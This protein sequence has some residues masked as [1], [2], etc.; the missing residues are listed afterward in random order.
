MEETNELEAETPNQEE[1][2]S[3]EPRVYTA[4]EVEAIKKKM[5]SD[6]E[7][8]VQ[9]LIAKNK[10]YE[11]VLEVV[12]KV[13]DDQ[14]YLVDYYDTNPEVAQII[15]EKYYGGQS[16][17]EFKNSIGY[18]I[19]Y[20]DPTVR[21]RHIELEAQKIVEKKLVEK[22]KADFIA[23]LWMSEKEKKDFEEAFE[24][25]RQLKSF[26][27]DDLE[28]QLTKAYRE[29]SDNT[30]VLKNLK[31]QEVIGKAMATWEGKWGDGGT[32]KKSGIQSEIADFLKKYS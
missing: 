32:V 11:S 27:I 31:T 16:I 24:E 4:E 25:R 20:S 1:E 6:S 28:K 23:K 3:L 22:S 10:A 18:A 2:S 29:I 12:G 14:N 7:K 19:D 8:W 17:E 26:K 30:E 13:A 5:Q 21:K 15:L 9:K